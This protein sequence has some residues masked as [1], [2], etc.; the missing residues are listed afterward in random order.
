MNKKI[1]LTVFSLLAL[2][3]LALALL[4]VLN[5]TDTENSNSDRAVTLP[6]DTTTVPQDPALSNVNN[7]PSTTGPVVM[8]I[9]DAKGIPITTNDFIHNGTTIPDGSNTERYLLAGNLGYCV[10]DP[11][12]CQAGPTDD[13]NIFYDEQYQ[14]FTIALLK[15]PVGEVRFRMEQVLLSLLGISKADMCRLNYYVGTQSDVNQFFSGKNLSFS[16]C[17]GAT[18]LPQ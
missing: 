16:Y 6:V 18:P 13:F 8:V 14:S 12:D 11:S 4:L 15:E 1:I 9:Q 7:V 5:G 2:G 17:P 3:G 10:S